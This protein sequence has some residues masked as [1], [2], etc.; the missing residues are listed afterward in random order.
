MSAADKRLLVVLLP[1]ILVMAG[2]AE[3]GVPRPPNC[4]LNVTEV[5]FGATLPPF[6]LPIDI[7]KTVDLTITNK[8]LRESSAG[9]DP[10]GGRIEFVLSTPSENPP[11]FTLVPG[12]TEAEFNIPADASHTVTLGATVTRETTPGLYR[13]FVLLNTECDSIPFRLDI[14]A[15]ARERPAFVAQWGSQGDASGQFDRPNGIAVDQAGNVFV[16]D[17]GNLRVQKFGQDGN[18]IKRWSS[19]EENDPFDAT[20][21]TTT[22]FVMSGIAVDAAG[23]VY[24][25]DTEPGRNRDR[26]TVFTTQGEFAKRWGPTQGGTNVFDRPWHMDIGSDGLVHVVDSNRQRIITFLLTTRGLGFEVVRTWGGFGTEPGRFR[27][28]YGIAV[29]PDRVYVSDWTNDTVQRFSMDGRVETVWGSRGAGGGQF[30][31]PAGI[32]LDAEGN[33]YVVDFGNRRVQMF[34]ENGAFLMS[35]GRGGSDPGQFDEPLD[36]A[37]GP[38]GAIYVVDSGNN[39]IQKFQPSDES[40]GSPEPP[41]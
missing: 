1:W 19:W 29:G 7:V 2:C 25:S 14:A 16:S 4:V 22:F 21:Q 10:L 37:V 30:Q 5:N 31:H 23:Q 26:I 9:N 17:S 12:T 24:V 8:V 27:E 38:D 35:F 13:G 28:P 41:R 11:R 39:R 6:E 32:D 18:Y 34:N 33:L 36:V 20:N 3:E 40:S 15:Q